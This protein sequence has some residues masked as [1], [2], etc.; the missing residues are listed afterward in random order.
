M[1]KTLACI[2]AALILIAPSYTLAQ[3]PLDPGENPVDLL[4]QIGSVNPGNPGNPSNPANPLNPKNPGNPEVQKYG[5][6]G[7]ISLDIKGMDIIDALKLL[8]KQ[9]DLNIVAGKNVRGRVTLFLKDVDPWYAFQVILAA[10][11]LAYEERNGII[12]VMAERDYELMYGEKFD[13]RQEIETVKLEYAPAAE[14]AKTLNQIKTKIGA[15]I[16]DESSN[17]LIIKDTPIALDNMLNAI[18]ELDAQTE[19]KVYN[20]N[21]ASAEKIK[22]KLTNSVSKLGKLEIDE[23]TNKVIITDTPSKI[24]E[25]DELI[26][27]LDEKTKQVLIEAK[28]IQIDLT[29]EYKLGVNWDMFFQGLE[30]AVLG[31]NF[32]ADLSVV[33][34]TASGSTGGVFK[35]GRLD[36]HKYQA[37]VRALEELGRTNTLSSPRVVTTNNEE[38]K[39]LVG[40][41][42]PYA[43][44]TTTTPSTGS[45][46]T[47][48]QITYLDLGVKLYV[49]PTIN[50]D[51]F[52]TMKIKPEVSST[53]SDYSYGDSSPRT[54]VPIVK[55]SQAE[56]TLMVKDGATIV[57]AG[58]I[59]SRD[60]ET[61][62]Q[63][64]F[65]GNI[66][67]IGNLFK[68]TTRGSDG[69]S[70]KTELVI[71]VTPRIIT[72]DVESE[73]LD[74]YGDMINALETRYDNDAFL[75][76][77]KRMEL[78]DV[79]KEMIEQM[80]E[81]KM[82]DL[83]LPDDFDEG[84]EVHLTAEETVEFYP[85]EVLEEVV[86][87]EEAP[88]EV[89][90]VEE[91]PQG[92]EETQDVREVR[93]VV[94]DRRRGDAPRVVYRDIPVVQ[95][96]VVE[97]AQGPSPV[98]YQD[99]VRSRVHNRINQG[100]TPELS[101]EVW[102]EFSIMNDGMLKGEP[103]ILEA[104]ND[105]L[106]E[107]TLRSVKEVS[108]FPPLPSDVPS[109]EKTYRLLISY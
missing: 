7:K 78:S 89:W 109:D 26:Q 53:T 67:I 56:S 25:I 83:T 75:G 48:Y 28:I 94:V 45:S 103:M 86:V 32:Q 5:A 37:T 64:P 104:T 38:A 36:Q 2:L 62:N 6:H 16:V 77:N 29:D 3:M 24:A 102:V 101:G 71:F 92:I 13:T 105:E 40:T 55:T 81:E 73:E 21:Y 100:L 82:Q 9:A 70:A 61:R 18:R 49:T 87:V 59:E 107:L 88:R 57:L 99:M 79:E 22:E 14:I 96:R 93:E 72:G 84:R 91:A 76:K 108:P 42:Q 85:E 68:S 65:L 4:N 35:L 46:I 10:N 58:L 12:T 39:I 69:Q 34:P 52:I 33:S 66:P 8:S 15:V 97:M 90:V 47:S 17:T 50:D 11:S 74:I 23:R 63:I 30:H 54:T 80:V 60:V 44:S 1:K 20:L 98:S 43:T 95:E 19:T 106:K 41:N 31:S 51:G 27:E